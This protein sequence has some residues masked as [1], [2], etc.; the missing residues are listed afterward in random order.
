[1]VSESQAPVKPG[2]LYKAWNPSRADLQ[3]RGSLRPVVGEDPLWVLGQKADTLPGLE[4]SHT[5][6]RN[7]SGILGT[8]HLPVHRVIV[9]SACW[10]LGQLKQTPGR[11]VHSGDQGG[12]LRGR[13]RRSH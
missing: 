10:G 11:R 1:M 8:L 3:E 9:G 6:Q 12:L 13:E 2:E 5:P 7:S 4:S